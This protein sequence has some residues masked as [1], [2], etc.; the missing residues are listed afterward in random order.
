MPSAV[1]ARELE[2][3]RRCP[4][5]RGTTLRTPEKT[6]LPTAPTPPATAPAPPR[7]TRP[8]CCHQHQYQNTFD[9]ASTVSP[10]FAHL[11]YEMGAAPD[12]PTHTC[13]GTAGEATY[14]SAC[15]R[16]RA[17]DELVSRCRWKRVSSDA[18]GI[19]RD[20][21]DALTSGLKTS[22]TLMTPCS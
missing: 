2:V 3:A 19:P 17:G 4:C 5:P 1:A 22:R 7:A 10:H 11:A 6:P 18:L 12:D 16:S 9:T 20:Y 15:G 13:S 21:K 8:P 14:K